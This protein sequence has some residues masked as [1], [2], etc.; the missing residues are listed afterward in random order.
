MALTLTG[1]V[2]K[3][4]AATPAQ[5]NT[6]Q[7]LSVVLYCTDLCRADFEVDIGWRSRTGPSKVKQ[8][9]PSKQIYT[10]ALILTH[11]HKYSCIQSVN[12]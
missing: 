10:L 6:T 12:L 4:M 9:L 11:F 1:T 8:L 5:F 3:H 7:E 2:Q